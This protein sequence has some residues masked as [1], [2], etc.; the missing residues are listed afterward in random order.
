MREVLM[1]AANYDSIEPVQQDVSQLIPYEKKK[2][3]NVYIP[4]RHVLAVMG[5]F[6]H[7]NMYII[8]N[9]INVVIVEMVGPNHGAH[10]VNGTA[11]NGTAAVESLD[12]TADTFNWDASQQGFL[13]G[14]YYY[15][16][17]LTQIAGA[18][19]SHRFGSR[20]VIGLSLLTSSVLTVI[21]PSGVHHS[22]EMFAVLQVMIGFFSGPI[23]A[24]Y[25]GALGIW[26]PP[27]ERSMMCSVGRCGEAAGVVVVF[28]VAGALS[29]HFGWQSAYYALGSYVILWTIL[30]FVFVYDSPERH[31]SISQKEKTYIVSA[32]KDEMECRLSG[33]SNPREGIP[34]RGILTS[35]QVYAI[36]F[37]FYA[38]EWVEYTVLEMLPT[39]M[40]SMFK[41]SVS[42]TGLLASIPFIGKAILEPLCGILSDY[43]IKRKYWSVGAMR[44][45]NTGIGFILPGV[46]MLLVAYIN[47]NVT[48]TVVFFCLAGALTAFSVP[49]INA[50]T[51]DIAPNYSG[52]LF[53]IANTV[54]STAGFLAPLAAGMILKSGNPVDNWI[55]VY[56]ISAAF[57]ASGT[58]IFAIFGSGELQPWA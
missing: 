37:C 32:L 5:F 33:D 34:W 29:Q 6:A 9:I 41:L 35:P 31:P 45:I 22:F 54:A 55:I 11:A 10:G 40:S 1:S 23:T 56:W 17:I 20:N 25:L 47:W 28:P 51:L 3:C 14:C 58:V 44:K 12:S 7:F 38:R 49:G 27:L 48:L 18:W 13:I 15:G 4:K 36:I 52:I 24:A 8:R 39:Y 57:Y 16:Y 46:F 21:I 43:I 19:L 50:N 53:G 30:W 26:S 42:Q 2:S